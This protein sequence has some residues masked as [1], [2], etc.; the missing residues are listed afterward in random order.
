M[1][2]ILCPL[3]KE[4]TF[5]IKFF[6]SHKLK[7][8]SLD[9]EGKKAFQL[10]G[11]NVFFAVSGIG[12]AQTAVQATWF[13][14]SLKIKRAILCGSAGALHSGV[15]PG[16][17][18]FS[19]KTIEHDFKST[20]AR[21]EC[22]VFNSPTTWSE[23][24][25]AMNMDELKQ[26]LV[27]SGDEDIVD[28]LRASELHQKTNA[29]VVAWEGAGFHRACRFLNVEGLELRTVTDNAD[30]NTIQD[31]EKNLEQGMFKLGYVIKSI[32]KI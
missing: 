27:A 32:L 8:E 21:G 13:I 15:K 28:K 10:I 7:V 25:V 4:L 5:L 14:Q 1:I 31:F 23:E 12:K 19:T 17:V 29:D 2:L 20:F 6:E 24:I 9:L 18:I 16:D 30:H 26:G 3:K 11:A 22:P